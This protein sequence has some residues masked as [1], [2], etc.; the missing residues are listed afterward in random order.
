M[1][2][3]LDNLLER[4]G[5]FSANS[6]CDPVDFDVPLVQHQDLEIRGKTGSKQV[7]IGDPRKREEKVDAKSAEQ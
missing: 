3:K 6:G 4:F 2:K 1:L 7:L 5:V